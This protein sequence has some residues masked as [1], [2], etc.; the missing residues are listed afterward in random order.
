PIS[1]DDAQW[2]NQWLDSLAGSRSLLLSEAQRAQLANGT[3]QAWSQRALSGLYGAF[4]G[5]RL[6]AWQ[7]DPFGLFSDWVQERARET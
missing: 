6:G 3:P 2:Q 1:G 5:P 4:G 7:D